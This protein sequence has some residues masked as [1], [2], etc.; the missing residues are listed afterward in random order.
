[1]YP[2]R[3]VT[4]WRLPGRQRSRGGTFEAAQARY[5]RTIHLM[6]TLTTPLVAIVMALKS[7]ASHMQPGKWANACPSTVMEKASTFPQE[8]G[9]PTVQHGQY[10]LGSS[11]PTRAS[12][13]YISSIII[14]ILRT[15]LKPDRRGGVVRRGS[16]LHVSEELTYFLPRVCPRVIAR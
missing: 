1:M 5:S 2:E 7:A 4:Q 15:Q 14:S 6:A 3:R 11:Q 9:L 8:L 12:P 16:C 10:M 13:Y